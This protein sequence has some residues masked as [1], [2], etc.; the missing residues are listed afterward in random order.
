MKLFE[1]IQ[2]YPPTGEH[3]HIDFEI[4]KWERFT[5]KIDDWTTI[6]HRDGNAE[7]TLVGNRK[8][9]EQEKIIRESI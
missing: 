7:W 1:L 3:I 6:V 5:L 9:T 4:D 8:L 2:S